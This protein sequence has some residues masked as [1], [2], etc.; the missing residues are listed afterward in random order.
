MV[1]DAWAD[2][3][4]AM[5]ERR[6]RE[7]ELTFAQQ[8]EER[9]EAAARRQGHLPRRSVQRAEANR[10]SADEQLDMAQTEVRRAE[11]ALEHSGS[12]TP[13]TRPARA[14]EQIPVRSPLHGVV[15]EKPVTAGHGGHRGTPLFVVSDLTELW[16][17]AEV[18]E[19]HAPAR[20]GRPPDGAARRRVPGRDVRRHDHV[21]R[22][23]W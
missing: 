18:D 12:R 13:R 19:T 9:A 16:A 20:E 1:H 10:V 6:R 15:L 2:Y 14:G 22:P 4:K 11:E 7:T 5:A 8:N 21:R 17:V 3:R 23:T